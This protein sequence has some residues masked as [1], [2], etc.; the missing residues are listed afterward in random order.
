MAGV[1]SMPSPPPISSSNNSMSANTS[2]NVNNTMNVIAMH[3]RT[4]HTHSY[5]ATGSTFATTSTA[6]NSNSFYQFKNIPSLRVKTNELFYRWFSQVDRA[7]Q[8]EELVNYIKKN[9]KMPKI[10]DLAS[11]RNVR[12]E[13]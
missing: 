5:P 2:S 11:F 8:I 7:S 10:T 12:L 9:N 3:S 4:A 6:S 13:L 1:L